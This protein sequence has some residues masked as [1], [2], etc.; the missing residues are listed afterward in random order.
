MVSVTPSEII[1]GLK[2]IC[3][4]LG[5][6]KQVYSDEESSLR[7]KGLLRFVNEDN[8]K[9]IQTLTHAHGIE[10]FICTFRMHLQRILDALNQDIHEWVKHD[11][12]IVDKYDNTLNN[13][14]QIKPNEALK[15]SSHLW[16]VWHLQ[17]AAKNNRQ[18]EELKKG[19][20]IR[21]MIKQQV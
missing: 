16:V 17:N 8:I 3:E 13:T 2:L 20:M 1:R 11:N 14:I 9:T 7:S 4:Q 21:I 15:P 19:D 12:N 18:Y 5:Q 6:P 10:R